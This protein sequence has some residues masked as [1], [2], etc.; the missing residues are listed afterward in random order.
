MAA[1]R[2]PPASGPTA[3]LQGVKRLVRQQ[4][5]DPARDEGNDARR[6]RE[7]APPPAA[8]GKDEARVG[9]SEAA[10]EG[11]ADGDGAARAGWVARAELR[12][13]AHGRRDREAERHHEEQP[14]RHRDDGVRGELR[15][16][17]GG[18]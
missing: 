8:H 10:G 14:S 9:C 1:P 17:T 18:S 3:H 6:G 5:H 13:D 11:E 7:E 2:E 4:Q 12:A 15:R 16:E